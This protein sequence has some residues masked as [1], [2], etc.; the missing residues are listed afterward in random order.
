M[1]KHR[2]CE[3]NGIDAVQHASMPFDHVAEVFHAAIP[4]N[5]RHGQSSGKTHPFHPMVAR[6]GIARPQKHKNVGKTIRQLIENFAGLCFE[7]AFHRYY[8]IE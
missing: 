1:E 2:R 6:I 4:F 5:R 7:P 3:T 8:S